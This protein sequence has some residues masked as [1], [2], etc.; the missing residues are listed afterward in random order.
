MKRVGL[1]AKGSLNLLVL[2]DVPGAVP[3]VIC[4][5]S[6][7]FNTYFTFLLGLYSNI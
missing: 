6:Y 1:P 3:L 2:Q 4:T 7:D 5:I